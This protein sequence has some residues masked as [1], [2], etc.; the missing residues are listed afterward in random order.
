MH[1]YEQAYAYSEHDEEP[2]PQYMLCTMRGGYLHDR[3][4]SFMFL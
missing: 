4:T 3:L 1:C 2:D